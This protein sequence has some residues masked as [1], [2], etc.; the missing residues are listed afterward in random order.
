MNFNKQK[1]K[2]KSVTI[3]SVLWMQIL[4]ARIFRLD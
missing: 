2:N 4:G 1:M 3:V